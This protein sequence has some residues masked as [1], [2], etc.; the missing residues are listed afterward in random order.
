MSYPYMY[1]DELYHFGVKGMKWGVRRFQNKNGSYTSAGKGRYNSDGGS[2]GH[3]RLKKAAKIAGGVAGAAALAGGAYALS[4]TGVGQRAIKSAKNSTAANFVGYHALN[5]KDKVRN[6]KVGTYARAMGSTANH[7]I[8]K[9]TPMHRQKSLEK[10]FN[11]KAF[12]RKTAGK[13]GTDAMNR[14]KQSQKADRYKQNRAYRDMKKDSLKRS[15]DA[16]RSGVSDRR[17]AAKR[18]R[19][20]S[21]I[22]YKSSM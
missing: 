12:A 1:G 9:D 15:V 22:K 19:Q 10:T 2:A 3:P 21:K 18:R 16:I 13:A 17:T 20:A 5:A 6:S 4:K 11:S 14:F 8:K 7:M